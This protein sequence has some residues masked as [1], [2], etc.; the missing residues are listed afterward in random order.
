[1]NATA[2]AKANNRL[3]VK[4]NTAWDKGDLQS[5]FELFKRAAESGDSSSQLDLGYFF[6]CG[7]YVKTDKKKALHWYHL[8]YRQGDAGAATNIATVHRDCGRPGRMIWWFRRAVVMGDHD[9]LF[10]LGKCYETGI[11]VAKNLGRALRCYRH[12]LASEH[13][14]E[15]SREEATKRLSRLQRHEKDAV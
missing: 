2:R 14:T 10:E 12:L 9:A 5:A 8:A 4:A 6:D 13:V 11:G 1:M 3:F 15:S 7:L